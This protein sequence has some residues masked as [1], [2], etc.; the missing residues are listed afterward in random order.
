[1]VY[2]KPGLLI[3]GDAVSLVLNAS[4]PQKEASS[5][6]GQGTNFFCIPDEL[7]D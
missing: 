6:D 1:M 5:A 7:E 4:Y 3:V 2:A